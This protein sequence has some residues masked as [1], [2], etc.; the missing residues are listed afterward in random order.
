MIGYLKLEKMKCI[1]LNFNFELII[2]LTI[3]IKR[4]NYIIRL[5]IVLWLFL[6]IERWKALLGW[7]DKIFNGHGLISHKLGM[8]NMNGYCVGNITACIKMVN[9]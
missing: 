5:T 4:I 2:K 7:F 8:A 1:N 3:T 9:G 6:L